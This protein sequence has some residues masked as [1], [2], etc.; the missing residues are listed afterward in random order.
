MVQ[1]KKT[2]REYLL[3]GGVK[4]RYFVYIRPAFNWREKTDIICVTDIIDGR[5]SG[6]VHFEY[7]NG[8][9]D[10]MNYETAYRMK[11]AAPSQIRE[12]QERASKLEAKTK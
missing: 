2:F 3:E 4:G 6:A 12:F 1:R 11:E 10:S 9:K 8:E 7:P 5:G